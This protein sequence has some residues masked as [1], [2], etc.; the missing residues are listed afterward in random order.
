MWVEVTACEYLRAA[1]VNYSA[2]ESNE[3]PGTGWDSDLL[4]GL[5]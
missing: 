4:L 2:N 1:R 3:C 5:L